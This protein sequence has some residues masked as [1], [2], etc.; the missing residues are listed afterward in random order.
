MPLRLAGGQHVVVA[1]RA[2]AEHL[3]VIDLRRWRKYRG[4]V[5]VLTRIG[6]CDVCGRFAGG[7]DAIVAAHAVGRYA[8]MVEMHRK[9]GDRPMARRAV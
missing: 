1:T 2:H 6:R 7:V 9:P 5:A 3:S 4:A 8:E